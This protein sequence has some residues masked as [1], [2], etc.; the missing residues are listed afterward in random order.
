M[1]PILLAALLVLLAGCT[2]AERP[3]TAP[4]PSTSVAPD[5]ALPREVR[6]FVASVAEP[7]SIPF[8]AT[9]H[10]QRKLGGG[11]ADVEVVA[12]PP[13]WTIS[14]GDISVTDGTGQQTCVG[15]RCREGVRD[16]VL[17]PLGVFSRFFATAPARSLETD[18]RRAGA[19]A[20]VGSTRTSAGVALRCLAVPI[21]GAT[22][23]TYCL[24]PQGVFGFV[25]T[26][27]VRYELTSYSSPATAAPSTP[28]A[29]P[30]M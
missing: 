28:S 8:R 11:E 5:R 27:F 4:G 20:A 13:A 21:D 17:A 26:P 10:V 3:S 2:S 29:T 15:G 16:E 1:R 14:S 7:G 22:P 19:G 30:E 9:Y 25:D 24:T 18:A 6:A 12:S 23:S